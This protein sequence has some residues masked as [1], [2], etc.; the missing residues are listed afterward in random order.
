MDDGL[1]MVDTGDN[2]Y[3]ARDR[4]L[5]VGAV[6]KDWDGMAAEYRWRAVVDHKGSSD[7]FDE[8]SEAC[9]WLAAA[10]SA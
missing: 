7:F 4:G 2:V 10:Y 1:A 3:E 8:F 9:E 5:R 6:V